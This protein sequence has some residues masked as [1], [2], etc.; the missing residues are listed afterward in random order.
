MPLRQRVCS[1]GAPVVL[2]DEEK[3]E[4]AERTLRELTKGDKCLIQLEDRKIE[5]K[6]TGMVGERYK[7]VPLEIGA[8]TVS[9]SEKE[10]WRVTVLALD[11]GLQVHRQRATLGFDN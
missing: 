6:Y 8:E 2:D 5:A 7:F 1:V 4:R 11:G 10:L 9:L 3:L